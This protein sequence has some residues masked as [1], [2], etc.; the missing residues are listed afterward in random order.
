MTMHSRPSRKGKGHQAD[1]FI[2]QVSA[3]EVV[4]LHCLIPQN[5]H[6]KI[7]MLAIQEDTTV[8]NLVR[9]AVE[10]LLNERS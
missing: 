2:N 3:E 8:T 5:T 6:R 1:E 9:E 7:R 4:Q 10:T